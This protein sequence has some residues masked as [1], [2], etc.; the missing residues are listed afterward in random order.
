MKKVKM[1]YSIEGSPDGMRVCIY[2]GGY[3][4][5]LPDKLADVFINIKA[6]EHVEVRKRKAVSAAPQNAAVDVAP[7]NASVPKPVVDKDEDEKTFV[8]RVYQL[9]EELDVSSKDIIET[10]KKIGIYARAPASGLSD[11][12]I[13]RI[14]KE[15]KKK[16]K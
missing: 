16:R 5:D 8:V 1:N 15:L 2:Q 10:A 3:E 6:A 4:Y 11:E 13:T 12:E 7:E 9:A 14:K